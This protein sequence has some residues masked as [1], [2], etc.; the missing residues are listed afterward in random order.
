MLLRCIASRHPQTRTSHR[1]LCLSGMRPR[2]N[3]YSTNLVPAILKRNTI[4]STFR[5]SG[6]R[7]SSTFI[8]TSQLHPGTVLILLG[9][10]LTLRRRLDLRA[11]ISDPTVA[12][13]AAR[14]L[15]LVL[16]YAAYRRR[17]HSLVIQWQSRNRNLLHNLL[18][19]LLLERRPCLPCRVIS[20]LRLHRHLMVI[21]AEHQGTPFHR[22]S[23]LSY[24]HLLRRP[25]LETQDKS[26]SLLTVLSPDSR[27]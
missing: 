10:V 1:I 22:H 26:P 23:S 27:I 25:K 6:C 13:L 19:R 16:R 20:S 5:T 17:K 12:S 2:T 18:R 8:R 15:R 24:R 14:A 7:A 4:L 9:K 11:H 3:D 21:C